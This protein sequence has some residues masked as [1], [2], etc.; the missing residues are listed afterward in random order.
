MAQNT[1]E[2]KEIMIT[3]LPH[4]QLN[5]SEGEPRTGCENFFDWSRKF[6]DVNQINFVFCKFSR[7]WIF[8]TKTNALS[9]P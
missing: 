3:K 1:R 8:G 4:P 9:S 2:I 6:H 5:L 7:L